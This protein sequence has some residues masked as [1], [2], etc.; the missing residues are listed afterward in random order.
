M[1]IGYARVSTP[2][3]NLDRQIA[4][5]RSAGVET[6]YREKASGKA[7]KGRPQLEKAIDALGTDDVLV[8]AEWDRATRS[9][10]DGIQIMQR[11]A[12]RGSAIK[13][14][15]KPHLDLTTAIGRGFLAFLSAL[16]EDE[17]ARIVSRAADGRREARS[18]GVK[19]G[20]K[21]K[22]SDHQKAKALKRLAAGDGCREIAR[23]MG[24]SHS[25]I[26]R[27]QKPAAQ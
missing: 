26:S 17:R 25:T 6:I 13:V 22:L 12:A 5:L 21:P 18:R 11:V 24:V 3:Q 1:L 19:F 23:D 16:A 7:V 2:S 8:V 4:A 9:M 27:L 20:P 14:L 10:M 15:D